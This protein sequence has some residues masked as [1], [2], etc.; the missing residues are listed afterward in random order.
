[1]AP[2]KNSST[3][4]MIIIEHS[5]FERARGKRDSAERQT[6]THQCSFMRKGRERER[7]RERER[8]GRKQSE[9]EVVT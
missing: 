3:K 5:S 1:L 4:K 8:R 9:V 7:E 2:V 6:D